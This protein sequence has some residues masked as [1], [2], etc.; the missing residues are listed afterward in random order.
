MVAFKFSAEQ[1]SAK[2]EDVSQR[3]LFFWHLSL[4]TEIL[5]HILKVTATPQVALCEYVSMHNQ[6]RFSVYGN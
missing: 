2:V 1:Q 4:L 3:L 5:S 6:S